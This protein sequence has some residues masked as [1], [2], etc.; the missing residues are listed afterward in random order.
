MALLSVFVLPVALL[1]RGQIGPLVSLFEV[2]NPHSLLGVQLAMGELDEGVGAG[3]RRGLA[4]G[5]G[6]GGLGR[7]EVG[8]GVHGGRG[9]VG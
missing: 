2:G 8:E 5:A 1:G 3:C 7:E 4:L 6:L 9:G